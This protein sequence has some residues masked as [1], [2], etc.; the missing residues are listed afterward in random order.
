M[1]T[2]RRPLARLATAAL[3]GVTALGLAGCETA[4]GGAR[5]VQV[6]RFHLAEPIAP[7]SFAVEPGPVI[8]AGS[9]LGPDSLETQSYEQA[10]AQEL[11]AQGFT[12]AP[13][14]KTAELIVSVSVDRG[15]RPD[16]RPHGAALSLG[17]GGA[18]FGRHTGVGGGVGTTVP[19]GNHDER[20]I[21]GTRMM[22]QIKR[23]S[24]GTVIW[25]GRAV[26][27]APGRSPDS[28]APAAISRLAHA[29]FQ[30]FPGESGRTI[31]VK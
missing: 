7:G 15:A 2:T 29:I 25:E 16:D 20:F 10:V 19:V 14:L 30:G 17:I 18:S 4:G 1:Q 12:Q 26:T 8:G 11:T 5:P 23:R 28:A 27:E 9:P 31:T 13:D 6:T 22:V 24:E 21:V 3:M